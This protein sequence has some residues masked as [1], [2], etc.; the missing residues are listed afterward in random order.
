MSPEIATGIFTICGAVVGGLIG[1][2][3]TRQ[4]TKIKARI[5]AAAR[6]RAV[7][8]PAIA[9]YSLIKETEIETMLKS[10]L[11]AQAAAIEEFRPFVPNQEQERYQKAWEDY[12]RPQSANGSVYFLDYVMGNS[13]RQLFQERIHA[14][15]K[16]AE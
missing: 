14:I 8:A 11:P 5:D 2:L 9:K 3:T 7:F 6:L 1:F 15:L 4:I 10:E 16:F 12:H 13:R